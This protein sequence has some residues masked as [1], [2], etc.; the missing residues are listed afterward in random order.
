MTNVIDGKLY[1]QELRH[2]IAEEVVRIKNEINVTPSLAVIL[3]GED[4]ASQIYVKNKIRQTEEVGMTSVEYRLPDTTTQAELLGLISDL[5]EDETINGI[6]CQ[7]PLPGHI[8][9][10]SVINEIAVS[11]D[12][13]GF[14][15]ANVG[16]L[17][18]GQQALVPC[19]P[20]GSLMLLQKVKGDL[21]G[22]HAVIVGRSNIVGK[23]MIQL[24]LNEGV[25]VTTVHSKTK[26]I[27]T[28]TRQADL[29]VVAVGK[30]EMVKQD[31][32]KDGAVII[33]VGINRVKDDSDTKSKIV[34]D[35]AFLEC[36]NK[37]SA[38]T[39]VPGGVGPMTIACL[40]ANTLVA[41]CRQHNLADPN[42]HQIQEDVSKRLVG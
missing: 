24:L 8:D 31:W 15:I 38:I 12:V 9:S 23:P 40:L 3:C 27:E 42:L 37:A 28:I 13:D 39:P 7:L 25:T 1:A 20:L 6:L 30:P 18:T 16:L 34:G 10:S 4:P 41:F 19:T 11:K 29:L 5:N 33:D 14:T 17:G 2:S 21:T 26:N 36:S 32:I 22:M 35:V